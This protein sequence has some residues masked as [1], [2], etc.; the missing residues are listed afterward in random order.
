MKKNVLCVKKNLVYI[1]SKNAVF[2]PD[3][4]QIHSWFQFPLVK[5][6]I[7][8][9]YTSGLRGNARFWV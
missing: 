7:R 1:L 6:S 9:I 4:Y 2:G 8:G 3:T 5:M